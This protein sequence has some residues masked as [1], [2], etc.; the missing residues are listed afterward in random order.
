[1]CIPLQHVVVVGSGL[2]GLTTALRLSQAGVAVTLLEKTAR[3]GGNSAKA[4]SGINGVPTPHQPGGDSLESFRNDTIASGKGLSVKPLVDVLVS[5]SSGAIEW[6]TSMGIDLRA[7]TQLGGHSHARTHRGMGPLPPGYAIISE[8]TKRLEQSLVRVVKGA[9]LSEL[10]STKKGV[11]GVAYN[12]CDDTQCTTHEVRGTVVLATGGYSYDDSPDGL[13]ARHRP[14]LVGLP[15][16][17]GA[18]TTGDGHR[19]AERAGA[20]LIH[21]DQVQ[22]HPTAF[23]L[24]KDPTSRWKFLCGELIRGIGGVLVSPHTGERFVNEL[25]TRDNVT[26]AIFEKC[27]TNAHGLRAV[28]LL[29]VKESDA[30]GA[31]AHID[32]YESQGLLTKGLVADAAALAQTISGKPTQLSLEGFSSVYYGL[33]TPA[34]HFSMG[35]VAINTHAQ[36]LDA[37]GEVIPGLYAVG[38]VAGGVHG[39]NRLGGSSLLECVVFGT[40]AARHIML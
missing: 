36:A 13:L 25:D 8:L 16:T 32:F 4:S 15:S 18:Q 12:V 31:R 33:V 28:A 17:N 10:L 37:R 14:D 30:E 22:V 34:V 20:H 3:F 29:V 38:E 21:M 11:V 39:G 35:G 26:A 19:V 1:M 27:K 6:L 7:V 23:V 9:T 5:H 24:M 40:A 2:A